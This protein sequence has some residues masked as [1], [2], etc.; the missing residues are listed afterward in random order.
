MGK[1]ILGSV[2]LSLTLLT[3]CGKKTKLEACT[4]I[5]IE[6]PE[7]EVEVGDVDIEGGE[8]EMVCGDKIIDVPWPEF[9][10]HMNLDPEE[11]LGNIEGFREQ[12]SCLRDENADGKQVSCNTPSNPNDYVSLK[13]NYDD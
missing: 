5:E 2:L 10:K 1:F 7:A 4:F 11:Y 6:K 9:K 13:F 8:V 12:V 3:A